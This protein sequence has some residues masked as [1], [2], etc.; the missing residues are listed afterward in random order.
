[1]A[2]EKFTIEEIRKYIHSR[3]SFGDVSYYLSAENIKKANEEPSYDIG[4]IVTS[5]DAEDPEEEFEVTDVDYENKIVTLSK[6]SGL[7]AGKGIGTASFSLIKR[8]N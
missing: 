4:D 2:E 6:T 1:M 8:V 3:D 5:Q 7:H